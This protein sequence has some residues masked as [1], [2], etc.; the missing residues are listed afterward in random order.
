[1]PLKFLFVDELTVELFPRFWK[2]SI[3]GS[4]EN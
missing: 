3:E 4:A 2:N 1:L